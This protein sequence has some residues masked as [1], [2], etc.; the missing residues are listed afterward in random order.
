MGSSLLSRLTFAEEGASARTNWS[1]N[2]TY[3]TDQLE[4]PADQNEVRTIV[5][6]GAKLKALGSRHS[7]DGIADTTGAQVSLKRMSEMVIDDKA[8][9]VTVG[10]GVRYGDL[11]PYLDKRGYALHNLAS[12]PHITVVG[13]CSTGTHGVG[14]EEWEFV[15]G[16]VGAGDGEGGWKRGDALEGEGR[17]AVSGGGG[18]AWRGWGLSRGS[19]WICSRRL[20]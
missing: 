9:T 19:R 3:N 1:G 7:F 18:W 5:S 15:D 8:R 11:A 17:G 12:L 6:R 2:Y 10:A 16:G 4:S 20:R 14:R 13:A